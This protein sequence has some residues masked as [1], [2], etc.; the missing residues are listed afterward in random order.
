MELKQ[1][2]EQVLDA[3]V[4]ALQAAERATGRLLTPCFLPYDIR[5]QSSLY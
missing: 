3:A 2:I 4:E 1:E 5:A